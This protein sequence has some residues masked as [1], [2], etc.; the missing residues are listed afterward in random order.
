MRR[1]ALAVRADVARAR[2]IR[3]EVEGVIRERARIMEGIQCQA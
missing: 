2:A 1:V 3:E